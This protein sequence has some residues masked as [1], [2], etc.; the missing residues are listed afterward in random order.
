M[1]NRLWSSFDQRATTSTNKSP[2]MIFRFNRISCNKN[3]I[4]ELKQTPKPRSERS[5][6]KSFGYDNNTSLTGKLQFILRTGLNHG[7]KIHRYRKSA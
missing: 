2:H 1:L 4:R 5:Y 6:T 3:S 7:H